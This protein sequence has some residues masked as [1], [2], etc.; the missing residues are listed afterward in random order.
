MMNLK[1]PRLQL[2]VFLWPC[3]LKFVKGKNKKNPLES[4]LDII[5]FRVYTF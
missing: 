5:E 4:L 1:V 2:R 3:C